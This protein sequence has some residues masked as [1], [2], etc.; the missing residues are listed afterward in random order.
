MD[1]R[2]RFMPVRAAPSRSNWREVGAPGGIRT[3]DRL[4]RSH[5]MTVPTSHSSEHDSIH[6]S[7]HRPAEDSVYGLGGLPRRWHRVGV[8]VSHRTAR[9]AHDCHPH[10]IAQTHLAEYRRVEVAQVVDPDP[11]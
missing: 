5:A 3:P 8:A 10:G 4:I 7:I 9:V 11:G 6:R 1:T 2:C